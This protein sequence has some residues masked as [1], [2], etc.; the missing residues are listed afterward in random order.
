MS[1]D[2]SDEGEMMSERAGTFVPQRGGYTAFV[3]KPLPPKDLDLDEGLLLL[4]SKAD[5]ALARLDGVTQVLPNPDLFVAMYIKKEALLSSQIEGTQASL[6]G[7]LEFEADLQPEEDINEV[8]EV[9]NYIQAMGHGMEK[10]EFSEFSIDL[11]NEIHRFLIRGTRGGHKNPGTIRTEQNWIG[12]PGASI[13][14]AMYVPPPP[15]LVPDLMR[16]LE[17]FIQQPDKIP[18][19]IKASLIHA[20][21]ESIHPY[22]DG[23]GRMGRLLITFF[24]YSR[25]MLSKPLLYLSFYLKK[26]QQEY[27]RILND[28]RYSG[29]WEAWIAFFLTGVIETSTNSVETAKKII[30]LRSDLVNTL[31]EKNIG[32]VTALKF[33][34]VLFETPLITVSRAAGALDISRQTAN[35]LVKKFEDAGILVEITGNKRYK[36]YVFSDYLRIVQEGTYR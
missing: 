13:Q 7:V 36:R 23:N 18:L 32:G 26:H 33:I 28:I 21:F 6:R 9:I 19:L 34:D 1:A 16:N 17:E 27:Y 15:D 29:N 22:L 24:L 12:I 35:A 3:P 31:L 25:G 4:L 30:G 14:D 5:T 8:R 10:L 11:L 2:G 20:Q